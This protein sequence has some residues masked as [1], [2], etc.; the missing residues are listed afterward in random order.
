MSKYLLTYIF[1]IATFYPVHFISAQTDTV[2]Y[3]VDNK[4]ILKNKVN[5]IYRY[6]VINKIDDIGLT[7]VRKFNKKGILISDVHYS[8]YT[9]KKK[10]R[11]GNFKEFYSSGKIRISSEYNE[12]ELNGKTVSYFKNGNIRAEY[13]FDNGKVDKE[14]SRCFDEEGKPIS[15][16][17]YQI[18]P[19][20]PG[21]QEALKNY[22]QKL[23]YP[24]AAQKK[25]IE[26][27]V[28]V[29]FVVKKDGAI[30][31]IKVVHSIDPLLDQEAMHLVRS[32]PKW[33]PGSQ[34][35]LPVNVLYTL[36]INFKL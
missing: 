28:I 30:D 3:D 7:K 27:R 2:Y 20:F 21:G 5:Q 25:K 13:W 19:V 32:M 8:S 22:L 11:Q 18:L 9:K 36:P 33:T 31:D 10:I 29:R 6:E 35:G 23:K 12:N 24:E 26:G 14:K 16:I 15:Y 1:I 34:F 17:H 4:K